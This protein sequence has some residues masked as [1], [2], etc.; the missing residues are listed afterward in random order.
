M[1]WQSFV[2]YC[3]YKGLF[4]FCIKDNLLLYED[5][6]FL[7]GF[8]HILVSWVQHIVTWSSVSLLFTLI[9]FFLVDVF[10]CHLEFCYHV[11]YTFLWSC[12]Y[13]KCLYIFSIQHGQVVL[14]M[15]RISVCPYPKWDKT[16]QSD[17]NLIEG[18]IHV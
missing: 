1:H 12:D 11:N 5:F 10:C 2:C 6:F 3:I 13:F 14:Y 16:K 17:D 15:L 4:F 18:M 9:C 7:Q 8:F